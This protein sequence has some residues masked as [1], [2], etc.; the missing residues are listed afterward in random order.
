[1]KTILPLAFFALVTSCASTASKVDETT[2]GIYT[3]TSKIENISNTVDRAI[4]T[5]KRLEEK[6]F[7]DK[8]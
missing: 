2:N 8:K 6:W 5:E 7:E 4:A 3:G 1:M